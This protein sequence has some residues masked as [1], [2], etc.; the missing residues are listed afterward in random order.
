MT[1]FYTLAGIST[2]IWIYFRV[3]YLIVHRQGENFWSFLRR[4]A[5]KPGASTFLR[6]VDL[7]LKLYACYLIFEL[8]R[9][10][11]QLF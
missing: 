4:V 6:A 9:Y 2:I 3:G 1:L 11:W 8:I 7:G 5:V 10:V